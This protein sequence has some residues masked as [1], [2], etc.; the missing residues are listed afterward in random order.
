MIKKKESCSKLLD[1]R[2]TDNSFLRIY[3]KC[4]LFYRKIIPYDEVLRSFYVISR[5]NFEDKYF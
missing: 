2:E 5:E 1:K 4:K 3:F